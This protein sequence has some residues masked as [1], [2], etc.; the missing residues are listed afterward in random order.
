MRRSLVE[1]ARDLP[2]ARIVAHPVVTA[3][4]GPREWW[5]SERG[6]LL[7]LREY[8]KFLGALVLGPLGWSYGA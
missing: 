3:G 7:V 2:R 5:T 6:V 4:L 8:N 1:F